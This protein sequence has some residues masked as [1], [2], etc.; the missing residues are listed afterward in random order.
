[1]L[2]YQNSVVDNI[3]LSLILL[4]Q[5][6]LLLLSTDTVLF[7]V[8]CKNI[9]ILSIDVEIFCYQQCFTYSCVNRFSVDFLTHI[10][11]MLFIRPGSWNWIKSGSWFSGW[12][13]YY[14]PVV[15]YIFIEIFKIISLLTKTYLDCFLWCHFEINIWKK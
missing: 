11:K 8:D 13:F 3:N 15:K 9:I 7:L 4:L 2:V 6:F 14:P 10:K 5:I 1:M 12:R